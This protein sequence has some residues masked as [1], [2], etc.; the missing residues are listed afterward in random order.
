MV[1]KRGKTNG[2]FILAIA[3]SGVHLLRPGDKKPKK[4]FPYEEISNY[5]GGKG[6]FGIVTGNLMKPRR[7]VFYTEQGKEIEEIYHGYI[8]RLNAAKIR[9]KRNPRK[10]AG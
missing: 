6:T 10:I 4:S 2:T 5:V 3:K 8:T 9:E 1:E 7:L